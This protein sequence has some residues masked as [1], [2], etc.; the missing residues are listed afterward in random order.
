MIDPFYLNF[1]RLRCTNPKC[2]LYFLAHPGEDTRF[3]FTCQENLGRSYRDRN[4]HIAPEVRPVYIYK[5]IRVFNRYIHSFT[6]A[7]YQARAY[8]IA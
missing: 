1:V 3:C 2:D 6:D 7:W 4:I 5:R 8:H